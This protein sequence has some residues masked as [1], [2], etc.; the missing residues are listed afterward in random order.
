MQRQL[1]QFDAQALSNVLWGFV[2]LKHR[3]RTAL[4]RGCEA[5]AAL[6]ADIFSTQGM[7]RCYLSLCA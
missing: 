7:V 6:I 1:P 4:L 5:R 3:P 2:K